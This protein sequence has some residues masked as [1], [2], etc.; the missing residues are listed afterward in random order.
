MS[1][2][3]AKGS[4][5]QFYRVTFPVVERPWFQI[6]G[7]RYEVIDVSEYG[8]KFLHSNSESFSP[9]RAVQGTILFHDGTSSAVSGNVLRTLNLRHVSECIVQ[10]TTGVP[11]SQITAQQ[12]Y[13]KQK[14]P[15]RKQ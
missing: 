9:G 5:R 4:E 13:L 11:L 3:P 15:G 6:D 10:L 7:R 1:E 8:V 2:L 14:F 12:R